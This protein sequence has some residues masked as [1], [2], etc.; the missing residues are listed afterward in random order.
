MNITISGPPGSG[1]ST[2]AK[3]L[4]AR[5]KMAALIGGDIF[6]NIAKERG[7]TLEELGAYCEKHPEVDKELD[8][9][10]KK[11][12]ETNDGLVIESRISGYMCR[13]EFKV[14]LD[15][16]I[17]IR[18]HR[19]KKRKAEET[20][21]KEIQTREKSE[22]TRYKKYYG[23]DMYDKSIYDLMIDTSDL[24]IEGTVDIIVAEMKK[25]KLI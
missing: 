24:T 21:V 18:L 6:R 16:P 8:E 11:E 15:A 19:L 9:R 4:A 22:A 7:M 13:A 23:I 5:L 17:D 1:K 14:W 20:S 12:S 2:T 10:L 3:A 25:K